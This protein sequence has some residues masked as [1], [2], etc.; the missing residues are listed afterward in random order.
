[1]SVEM[2]GQMLAKTQ[3]RP[4]AWQAG[5]GQAT[6]C[7]INSTLTIHNIRNI[8]FP[9]DSVSAGDDFF[10]AA[11]LHCTALISVHRFARKP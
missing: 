9:M 11:G 3:T 2:R 7:L 5:M 8:T 4:F 1:M 10:G 6:P